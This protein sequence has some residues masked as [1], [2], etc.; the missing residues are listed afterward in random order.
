M[1]KK[2]SVDVMTYKAEFM[3]YRLIIY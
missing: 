1:P 3:T 2:Y